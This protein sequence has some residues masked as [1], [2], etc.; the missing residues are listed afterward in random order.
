MAI[1]EEKQRQITQMRKKQIIDAAMEL[2]DQNGY[3]NTRISDITEKA[4]ISKGL[5]YHYF[6]SKEEIVLAVLDRV[7]ECVRECEAIEDAIESLSLFVNRLLS[8]PYYENYVPPMRVFFTAMIRGEIK[9]EPENNPIKEDFGRTYFSRIFARGQSQ[10]YFRAGDPELFGEMF[11]KYLVGCMATMN[12]NEAK[13]RYRPD[14]DKV[15]E[16]FK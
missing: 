11:W 8:Y 6:R 1:S 4:G 14:I 3:S 7:E 9:V 12:V 2:F 16:L 15:L 13:T 10:G 5:A